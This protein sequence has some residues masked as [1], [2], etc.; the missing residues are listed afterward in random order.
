[1]KT[2]SLLKFFVP[3]ENAF[4][5]LFEENS[6]NL[7]K[8]AMLLKDLM[9]GNTTEEHERIYKEIKDIE[10]KGDEITRRTY[11]QINKSFIT[12]FDREDIHKLTGY[13]DDAVDLI[14]IIGRRIILYKPKK[15]IPVFTEMAS[16]ILEAAREIE[17]AVHLLR[18]PESNKM[19]IM[20]VCDRVNEIEHKADE[21]YF[22]GAMDLF[23]NET[24]AK[25]LIKISKI[26]ENLEKCIDEEDNITSTI[27]TIV[28]KIV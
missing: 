26:L 1:M 3:K 18:H 22:V 28:I 5:N 17:T 16:L 10:H 12:S 8:S 14:D 21:V 2:D 9:S 7:L 15:F 4:V 27:K 6:H 20:E 13:I 23:T 11:E 25:E 24:D 19:R